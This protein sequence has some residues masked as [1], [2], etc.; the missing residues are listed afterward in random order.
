MTLLG[1]ADVAAEVTGAG[2]LQT[3]VVGAQASQEGLAEI[4]SGRARRQRWLV[5]I[6]KDSLNEAIAEGRESQTGLAHESIGA[7]R[8]E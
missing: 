4:T 2:K 3:I 1:K 8:E 7:M 5:A 6:C